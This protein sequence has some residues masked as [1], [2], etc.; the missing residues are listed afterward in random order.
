VGPSAI[1]CRDNPYGKAPFENP[2]NGRVCLAR[3]DPRQ[4]GLF[5]AAY[6]LGYAAACAHGG[7]AA[8]ALG[9]PTGPFGFIHRHGDMPVPYFDGLAGPAVYPAFHVV[10]ALAHGSGRP[11]LATSVSP[12]AGVAALAWRESGRSVV[13][14]A[15]LTAAPV[16]IAL[17][18]VPQSATRMAV[19]DAASFERA[20][21]D[22]D[23]LDASAV[24]ITAGP[25]RLD[26]YAV[27]RLV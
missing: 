15:N 9:A 22:P 19:L 23:A 1:G 11:L 21:R 26:A 18:G 27:A 2:D 13:W 20:T 24:D 12:T 4:R 14:L 10:E 3:V 8:V 7:V 25:I 6:L 16:R 5:A 17:S